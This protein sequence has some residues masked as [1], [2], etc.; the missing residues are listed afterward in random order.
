MAWAHTRHTVDWAIAWALIGEWASQ[1]L[2]PPPRRGNWPKHGH[3]GNLQEAYK[4]RR[5]CLVGWARAAFEQGSLPAL[6]ALPGVVETRVLPGDSMFQATH[7]LTDY[8]RPAIVHGYGGAKVD[9]PDSLPALAKFGW[10]TLGA[11]LVGT[12][13][14]FPQWCKKDSGDSVR[15]APGCD[16][17]FRVAP[18]P[19]S[20]SEEVYLMGLWRHLTEEEAAFPSPA[21]EWLSRC[22][23]TLNPD[24]AY[25]Q[26]HEI[27]TEDRWAPFRFGGAWSASH[28]DH[29]AIKLIRFQGLHPPW[30]SKAEWEF[31][32][33]FSLARE[34]DRS[35]AATWQHT[36]PRHPCYNGARAMLAPEP[37]IVE[38]S[39]L[40]GGDLQLAQ[41]WHVCIKTNKHNQR[42]YGPSMALVEESI[43]L[44]DKSMLHLTGLGLTKSL[45]VCYR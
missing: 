24:Q 9:L 26:Y 13:K 40:G 16:V 4:R 42:I 12:C 28:R 1:E 14:Y 37:V 39:G 23:P 25:S 34:R 44:P 11:S 32:M 33:W 19:L 29:P 2:F 22:D 45:Q 6:L 30:V 21:R 10:A 31:L 3:D 43:R 27:S 17:S 20:L 18:A 5:P 35:W 38:C 15:L 41:Q 36:D 8:M 7:I